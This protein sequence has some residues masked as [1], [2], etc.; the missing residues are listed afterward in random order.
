MPRLART[1][2]A[3]FVYHVMNRGNGRLRLFHQ[4]GDYDAFE[5]IMAEGLERF[6]VDL[7]TYCL[8][9]NHW[10]FVVRPGTDAAL[11][12]CWDGSV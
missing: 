10:H 3:G 2:K 12:G 1:I 6:P 5:Q 8:M 7:L 4:E 11:G 9:P